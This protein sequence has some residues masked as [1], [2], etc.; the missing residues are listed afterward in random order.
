MYTL[1]GNLQFL[2]LINILWPSFHVNW[3]NWI[4]AF[5]APLHH[6]WWLVRRDNMDNWEPFFLFSPFLQ[7]IPHFTKAALPSLRLC[8][9]LVFFQPV[10]HMR[11]VSQSRFWTHLPSYLSCPLASLVCSYHLP[12]IYLLHIMLLRDCKRQPATAAFRTHSYLEKRWPLLSPRL[13]FFS[14]QQIDVSGAK[15]TPR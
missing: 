10:F 9:Q 3:K 7:R 13:L 8:L 15:F 12:L 2:P 1:F 5:I 11:C 14:I 4:L 6:P